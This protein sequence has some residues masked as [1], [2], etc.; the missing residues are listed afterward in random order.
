MKAFKLKTGF[1]ALVWLIVPTC[2]VLS[3]SSMQSGGPHASALWA[4]EKPAQEGPRGK[5]RETWGA[6]YIDKTRVGYE[7]SS[8]RP[9]SRNGQTVWQSEQDTFLVMKRFGTEMKLRTKLETEETETGELHSFTF[10]MQEIKEPPVLPTITRGTVEAGKLS[11]ET[12]TAGKVSK[13]RVSWSPDVKSP[14]FPERVLRSAPLKPGEERSFKTFSPEI[15]AVNTVT[16]KTGELEEVLLLAGAKRKLLRVDISQSLLPGIVTREYQDPAG[17][18]LKTVSNFLGGTMTAYAVTREEALK[19][20]P[21]AELD[22]GL[23]TLVKVPAI[24]NPHRTTRV[25]YRIRIRGESPSKLLPTG[26]TQ[27]VKKIEPEVAE[28]IVTAAPAPKGPVERN[29]QQIEPEYLSSTRFLQSDDPRVIKHSRAA[30]GDEADPWKASLKMERYVYEK[31]TKKNFSTAMASAAEVA[32]NLEGDCTEHAC[33][34]AA[35]ARANQIPS[36]IAVGMVYVTSLSSFAG[37]M[38]TEVFVDGRWIPLDATMAQGGIR[39]AHI[40]LFNSSFA[41]D[42]PVPAASFLP[43]INIIGKIEIEVVEVK[44]D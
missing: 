9:A 6:I 21:G 12:T 31:L 4:D 42:G 44:Y 39:A 13:K 20:V 19:A 33:L 14:A 8:A 23:D 5:S 2:L 10:Q 25:V 15:N 43:L 29:R 28:L 27:A 32:E 36:R 35:M 34:L 16:L 18:A 1:W 37:H 22:L 3:K 40:K 11:L 7:H 41:D 30:A 26:P 17:T 38:W 24:K